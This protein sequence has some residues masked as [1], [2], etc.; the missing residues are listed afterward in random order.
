[1]DKDLRR[2]SKANLKKLIA[3]GSYISVNGAAEHNHYSLQLKNRLKG[4]GAWGMTAGCY[5]GYGLVSFA[6]HSTLLATSIL[7]GPGQLAALYILE[8]IFASPI[9]TAACVGGIAGGISVGIIT[10]PI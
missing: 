7:A 6:G 10:G 3:A 5:L 8:Q 9:H 1:M 4:G 2:I